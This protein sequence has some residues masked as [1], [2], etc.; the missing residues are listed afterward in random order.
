MGGW[1]AGDFG[2]RRMFPG[3]RHWPI[4]LDPLTQKEKKPPFSVTL[5]E[6]FFG[7]FVTEN[8]IR[9]FFS[10]VVSG[11]YMIGHSLPPGNIRRRSPKSPAIHPPIPRL[12]SPGPQSAPAPN[13]LPALKSSPI[14]CTNKTF[15]LERH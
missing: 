7:E 15:H 13:S 6:P 2:L 10:F 12:L 14:D 3:G 8:V 11:S 4:I 5:S 9:G 1:M